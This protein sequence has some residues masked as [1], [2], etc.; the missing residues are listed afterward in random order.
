[1]K[2]QL[3]GFLEKGD[4]TAIAAYARDRKRTLSL[5]T[6]ITYHP[7]PLIAWRAVQG[8]GVAAR[9]I[10]SRDPE[11]VRGHLR[12]LNWL[13]SDE[14]GGIGWHA[15]ESIGEIITQCPGLFD[16]FTAPLFHFLDMEK[17]DAP[18]FRVGTL[19]AIGRVAKGKP[20]SIAPV[21]GLIHACTSQQD[22]QTRGMALWCLLQSWQK[23]PIKQLQNLCE[24]QGEFSLYQDGNFTTVRISMLAQRLLSS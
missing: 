1:L 9:E 13:V 3:E 12:R 4:F 20:E 10:A 5:L 14:S 23:A 18:R 15:P 8:L 16:E 17:E 19:W 24:D 22:I 6:G 7:Q 11:F 2:G 21:L